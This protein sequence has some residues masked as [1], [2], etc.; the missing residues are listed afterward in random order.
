MPPSSSLIQSGFSPAIQVSSQ[1]NFTSH[2]TSTDR[3]VIDYPISLIQGTF[4][5]PPVSTN[6][7]QGPVQGFPPEFFQPYP[8]KQTTHKRTKISEKPW[9]LGEK[10]GCPSS[11][12]MDQCPLAFLPLPISCWVCSPPSPTLPPMTDL[13]PAPDKESSARHQRHLSPALQGP[14]PGHPRTRQDEV[15][16]VDCRLLQFFGNG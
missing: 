4:H 14:F 15:L 1:G 5:I 11:R 8:I 12:A 10:Q 6:F 13:F 9:W 3:L 16:G 2:H 7:P